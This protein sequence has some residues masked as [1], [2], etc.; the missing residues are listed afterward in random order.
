MYVFTFKIASEDL[1]LKFL[2]FHS[3]PFKCEES[4]RN[5][6]T[7][8]NYL[9]EFK[10]LRDKKLLLHLINININPLRIQ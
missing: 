8:L 2:S 7:K 4:L 3:L 10:P 6:L 5:P 1:I 9:R